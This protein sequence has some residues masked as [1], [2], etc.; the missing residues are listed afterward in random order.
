ML[1]PGQRAVCLQ[2]KEWGGKMSLQG[3]EKGEPASLM[4]LCCHDQSADR[5]QPVTH[6]Y[7][8]LITGVMD[9]QSFL[10]FVGRSFFDIG[11]TEDLAYCRPGQPYNEEKKK[12]RRAYQVI[13]TTAC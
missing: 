12:C 1:I 5:V 4:S 8:L 10:C 6:I 9:G 13:L 11:R 7:L 3:N 2:G